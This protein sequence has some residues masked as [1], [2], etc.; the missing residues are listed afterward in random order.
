MPSR[1]VEDGQ[2]GERHRVCLHQP[3]L[4][5]LLQTLGLD[6]AFHRGRGAQL[7][8]T[9]PSG[10][11][12]EIL[13]MV[14]GYGAGLFGHANPVLLDVAQ[15]SLHGQRPVFAQ[16]SYGLA[17]QRLA[18]ELAERC[19]G[20]YHTVLANSGAE[21]VEAAMKHA[22]LETAGSTFVALGGGFHG[23]TLGAV[24]LTDNRFYREPFALTGIRV[25]RVPPNDCEA[26]KEAFRSGA[27]LGGMIVE[28]IQGEGGVMPL[29]AEFLRLA[30][31]LCAAAAIP[32]IADECQTGMGRTGQFLACQ[33]MG[34]RPDYVLLSK[35]LGGGIAKISAVL[36]DNRRYLT[37]FEL[38][39]SSTFAGDGLSSEIALTALKLLTPESL[40]RIRSQGEFALDRLRSLAADYPAAI[41]DVRGA[42]LML[43]IQFRPQFDSASFLLRLF[44]SKNELVQAVAGYLFHRHRIRAAPTLSEP[45]VLRL[46][47]S[48]Q[49]GET[50]WL[51]LANAVKDVCGKLDRADAG[52]LTDYVVDRTGDQSATELLRAEGKPIAFT[53]A[54]ASTLSPTNSTRRVAWLCHM[55]D[56]NDM[57]Q[58]EPKNSFLGFE[59]AEQYLACWSPLATPVVMNTVDVQ[60]G[61][62][63]TICFCPIMLPVTSRQMK[64]WLDRR[65]FSLCR[66][67]VEQGVATA[68]HLG[69]QL[70]AL[71]QYTSIVTQAGRKLKPDSAIGLTSGN[72]YAIAL[73]L[74]AID[75]VISERGLDRSQ[76]V[77]GIAGGAGNIGR[78]CGE[79]L[80]EQYRAVVLAGRSRSSVRLQRY[81]KRLPRTLATTDL[82]DLSRAHVVISATNAASPPL[83]SE[84]LAPNAIVCDLSVPPSLTAATIAERPDL[85]VIQ[86]GIARLPNREDLGIAS[87]PLQRGL[88]FGCMA[89][90]MLLGFENIRSCEFTGR[91]RSEHV[92]RVA[93]MAERHGFQL[94]DVDCGQW[95]GA[96]ASETQNA[97]N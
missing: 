16:G 18:F 22:I 55:I 80:A 65:Q 90:G 53:G 28:P 79:I 78:A 11:E 63:E 32:L 96:H 87:F 95:E 91:L 83:G 14:G 9:D 73:A 35:S 61:H 69:C 13:D 68:R 89:E 64:R 27:A 97:A 82:T 7:V 36:I 66:A 57:I 34:V 72:S 15:R 1:E 56:A 43:G 59:M 47:P 92:R 52:G 10:R 39:H 41:A 76:L 3:H 70:A 23:K 24:Q 71:G 4:H 31:E 33:S 29:T 37:E 50:D 26:L 51:R 44:S 8:Y 5:L 45:W 46:Q 88:A 2:A 85:K 12:V 94:A 58:Q 19:G 48:M 75:R 42:G 21:A 38:R 86:G 81:A 20:G 77:L 62:G 17:S 49:V 40:A 30:S 67:L 84:H 6:V 60:S 25:V 54:D 74:G 93:A